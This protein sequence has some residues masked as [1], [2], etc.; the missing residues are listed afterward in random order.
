MTRTVAISCGFVLDAL[1]G[2]PYDMPHPVRLMGAAISRLEPVLRGAFA[3]TRAGQR[4]AGAVLVALVAGGSYATTH[5]ALKAA[6]S[7]SPALGFVVQ[8]LL[9]YQ[10]LAARQLG[11]E[12][13]KV[14]DALEHDGVE[15]GRAAVSMIVG[16]DTQ[17]LD[18]AGIVRATVETVAENASD[19]VVAPLLYLALGGAPAGMLY[20]AVSTMDSMVGYKNDR[21]RNFGT[22]AA[23]AD[24]V[25]NYVPARVTALL[26]CLVA[27]VVGL[28]GKAAW[29][30]LR[31]D[32]KRHASPNAGHPEAA[33][34]G[35]LGV[36]L[37]GPASYFG[38]VHDKPT[39]G[40]D[41]RPVEVDDITRSTKL[42]AATSVAAFVLAAG[43]SL[44]GSIC[45]QA[46]R[47][48]KG[49]VLC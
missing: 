11:V 8:T 19:G 6:R 31:R 4:A 15:A 45:T 5:L 22:A 33:C 32:R 26:M 38:K 14:R 13:L 18:Q 27:P 3:Q 29:R 16:R 40:D 17:E 12:A 24:D 21:Y 39:I 28:D 25:L 47:R 7:A 2:D 10:A 42:L 49:S 44:A 36:R 46:V 41:M 9:C 1:L 37:A 23:R 20:K 43:L 34:A 30:I 48:N 35:A